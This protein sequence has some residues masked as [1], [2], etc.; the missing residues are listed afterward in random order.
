MF[1]GRLGPLTMVALLSS[2]ERPQPYNYVE[3]PVL[4]A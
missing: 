1:V 3:E 4:I 2:R